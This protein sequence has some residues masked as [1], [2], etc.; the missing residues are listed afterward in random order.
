M[1]HL[2]R[3]IE[4][5]P[6]NEYVSVSRINT[7]I[8][9]PRKYYFN[10][11]AKAEKESYPAA[12]IFGSAAHSVIEAVYRRI[13]NKEPAIIEEELKDITSAQFNKELESAYNETE[14]ISFPNKSGQQDA[15]QMKDKLINTLVTWFDHSR[16]P[17]EVLAIEGKFRAEIT[18]PKTGEI[19]SRHLFGVVDAITQ[20]QGTTILE[21]HKTS[22]RK[23]T[24]M[25]WDYSLQS[26]LYLAAYPE[27]DEMKFNILIKTK[28]PSFQTETTERTRDEIKDAVFTLCRVMDAID[29]GIFYPINSWRCTGCQFYRQCRSGKATV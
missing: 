28:V 21:E 8:G 20:R 22:A 3:S 23:W 27:I 18:D 16:M 10:Y 26:S 1:N 2:N 24:N 25:D 17:D 7:Y 12:L 5:N 29:A 4:I 11:V 13:K 6:S 19:K 15:Q 9:C 14:Q